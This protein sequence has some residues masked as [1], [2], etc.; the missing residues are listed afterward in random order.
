V[1]REK[2]TF[3]FSYSLLE[4]VIYLSENCRQYT[5][6]NADSNAC[7]ETISSLLNVLCKWHHSDHRSVNKVMVLPLKL[8]FQYWYE[9]AKVFGILSWHIFWQQEISMKICE[10]C[11]WTGSV[12]W[13]TVLGISAQHLQSFNNSS[14]FGNI[15]RNTFRSETWNILCFCFLVC[16]RAFYWKLSLFNA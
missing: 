11:S 2:S 14:V 9:W 5:W 16:H 1:F 13:S 15:I 12:W 7:L 10:V 4:K 8:D 6:V 3:L